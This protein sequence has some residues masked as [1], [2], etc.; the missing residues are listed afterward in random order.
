MRWIVEDVLER[1]LIFRAVHRNE[2]REFLNF[3]VDIITA[4]TLF[5]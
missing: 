4:T 1:F 2:L 3:P 5:V